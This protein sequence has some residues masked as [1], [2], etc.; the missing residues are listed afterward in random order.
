LSLHHK[1][2]IVLGLLLVAPAALA[3]N[4]A[5]ILAPN[6][7]EAIID[8]ERIQSGQKNTYDLTVAGSA[9]GLLFI[10][11]K[12]TERTMHA[13][14]LLMDADNGTLEEGFA[15]DNGKAARMEVPIGPGRYTLEVGDTHG[16]T[17]QRPYRLISRFQPVSDRYE[18]N[19][20]VEQAKPLH[21]GEFVT[22]TLFRFKEADQ[23]AFVYRHS[24]GTL[25]IEATPASNIR[26][27]VKVLNEQREEV[28]AG[29]AANPG[30]AL[31]FD[32]ELPEGRYYLI[33]SDGDGSNLPHPINVMARSR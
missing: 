25:H 30:A 31:S 20:T 14:L 2:A 10:E 21:N 18:P 5:I 13:N 15:D 33:F 16:V 4:D 17:R 9:D 24:G 22:I 12:P 11:V 3:E 19:D 6:R 29:F 23:D 8:P 26:P 28:G 32:G 27:T 1:A 7:P